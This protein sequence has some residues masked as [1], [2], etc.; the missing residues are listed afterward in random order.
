MPAQ[1]MSKVADLFKQRAIAF[2]AF[3]VLADKETLTPE[4]RTDY[5]T[6]KRAVE[7]FDR[8]ITRAK[9]LQSMSSAMTEP[10]IEAHNESTKKC[11]H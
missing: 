6:K 9:D 8:Q 11:L 7:D 5:A 4:E 3:K 1:K 2:D 10:R